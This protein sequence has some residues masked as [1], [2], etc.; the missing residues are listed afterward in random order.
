M[1]YFQRLS[2]KAQLLKTDQFKTARIEK[3]K[4][5]NFYSRD[6]SGFAERSLEPRADVGP[7]ALVLV[8]LL[9]PAELGVRVFGAFVLDKIVRERRDLGTN[10]S[11]VAKKPQIWREN[12]HLGN[13]ANRASEKC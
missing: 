1:K 11:D 8:L 3:P 12:L 5:T 4:N 7:G 10:V 9:R 13:T 2:L 6:I